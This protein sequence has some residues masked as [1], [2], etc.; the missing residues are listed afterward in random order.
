MFK[1]AV[2][3]NSQYCSLHLDGC[4]LKDSWKAP[5]K[6]YDGDICVPLMSVCCIDENVAPPSTVKYVSHFRVTGLMLI[7][8]LV[9]NL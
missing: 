6:E 3:N 7:A 8:A 9:V 1:S 2:H 4:I 5:S